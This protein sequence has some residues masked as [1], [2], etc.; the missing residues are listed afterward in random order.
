MG[1]PTR[2][3][4][5]ETLVI[6]IELGTIMSEDLT[7]CL[8]WPTGTECSTLGAVSYAHMYLGLE[9][10][11]VVL[12]YPTQYISTSIY[13]GTSGRQVARTGRLKRIFLGTVM[14]SMY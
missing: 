8:P 3:G 13:E 12:M 1:L 9:P 2:W 11:P 14:R 7:L 4:G 5:Q 6:A 10:R